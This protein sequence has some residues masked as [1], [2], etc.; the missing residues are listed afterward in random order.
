[1]EAIPPGMATLERTAQHLRVSP[2]RLYTLTL[3]TPLKR[4]KPVSLGRSLG[5]YR[6]IPQLGIAVLRQFLV[7]SSYHLPSWH[8]ALTDLLASETWNDA[9]EHLGDKLGNYRSDSLGGG[10]TALETLLIS[11][12]LQPTMEALHHETMTVV[13]R[14]DLDSLMQVE[15]M[16]VDRLED[17]ND[18][19]ILVG[20]AERAY[21]LP[22]TLLRIAGLE[23]EKARGILIATRTETGIGIDVWPAVATSTTVAWRPDPDLLAQRVE[24]GA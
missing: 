16:I 24:V 11:S 19:V 18:A 3:Q 8:A 15:G 13:E 14:H 9:T 4:I 10:S 5:T 6:L 21:L 22:R 12:A 2:R 17:E 20:E 1:M 7:S 23:Y